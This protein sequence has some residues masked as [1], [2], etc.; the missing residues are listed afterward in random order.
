MPR[1]S[2]S[3]VFH[4]S[5]PSRRPSAIRQWSQM[6][7]GGMSHTGEPAS[8]WR[9]T[10]LHLD[11]TALHQTPGRAAPLRRF[12]WTRSIARRCTP[13]QIA[14]APIRGNEPS[15]GGATPPSGFADLAAP[16]LLHG[17]GR[18][19]PPWQTRADA[20]SPVS[21]KESLAE[22]GPPRYAHRNVMD[23]RKIQ[24]QR[25]SRPCRR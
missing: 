24:G 5:T 18:Q 11:P 21:G 13:Q 17:H 12:G 10:R 7:T 19:R 9:L 14:G 2:D 23:I 6:R 16:A 15:P 8:A 3:W 25:G 22:A 1:M 20:R 4:L